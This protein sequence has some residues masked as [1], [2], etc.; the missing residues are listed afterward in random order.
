[1]GAFLIAAP[2]NEKLTLADESSERDM[3]L[4]DASD[5]IFVVLLFLIVK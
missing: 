5:N 1:M 2:Y 4:A 3:L